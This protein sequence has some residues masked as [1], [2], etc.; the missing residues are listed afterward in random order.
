MTT[1]TLWLV[2]TIAVIGALLY[3]WLAAR[4]SLWCWF[5]AAVSSVI[6]VL[7]FW[8]VQLYLE[9]GLNFFYVV[10]A[11]IGYSH[12][13][14]GSQDITVPIIRLRLRQ[15]VLILVAIM[16][17]TFI[18]TTFLSLY[19]DSSRPFLDSL[20]T[21]ASLFSTYL[22]VQKVL[23]NWIYWF[24]ID[25]ASLLLYLERGLYQTAALFAIYLVLII[26]GWQ[27]WNK[28]SLE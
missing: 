13:K 26:L 25:S 12:W 7:I 19:S 14:A 28:Q 2:E 8:Q 27:R 24:F 5:F 11:Y 15:H 17:M 1:H 23:E 9:A 6:Y 21:W 18:S 10:M 3:L 16:V 4:E 22:V 20:I